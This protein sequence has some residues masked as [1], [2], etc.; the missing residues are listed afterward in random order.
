MERGRNV[1]RWRR[2]EG[3]DLAEELRKLTARGVVIRRSV[4]SGS[5]FLSSFFGFWSLGFFPRNA[6]SPPGTT[7]AERPSPC[8]QSTH[9]WPPA[10]KEQQQKRAASDGVAVVRLGKITPIFPTRRL[11]TDK[12]TPHAERP[13]QRRVPLFI[14]AHHTSGKRT[15]PG[16]EATTLSAGPALNLHPKPARALRRMPAPPRACRPPEALRPRPRRQRGASGEKK[17]SGGALHFA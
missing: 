7:R 11:E 2:G 12:I 9:R 1:R 4:F 5:G 13:V 14:H 15:T 6:P 17:L 16:L 3:G 8:T 10:D